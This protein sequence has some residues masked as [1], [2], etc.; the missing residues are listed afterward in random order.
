MSLSRIFTQSSK[1]RNLSTPAMDETPSTHSP[2]EPAE[3]LPRHALFF[4]VSVSLGLLVGSILI[5][6]ALATGRSQPPTDATRALARVPVMHAVQAVVARQWVGF[7]ISTAERAS[8]VPARVTATVAAIPE[9]TKEGLT[10][11]V[12]QVL[13]ELDAD[14]F[15]QQRKIADEAIRSLDAQITALSIQTESLVEQVS[16]ASQELELA[17]ADLGRIQSAFED[18]AARQREVDNA[19]QRR[20]QFARQVVLLTE[21]SSEMGPRRSQLDS[22]MSSQQSSRE[23]A[24]RNE[25]R[26]FVR[27]PIDG[28]L[29]SVS[30]KLGEIVTAGMVVARVVDPSAVEIELKLP[31]Q[32][33]ASIALG[34]DAIVMDG[35]LS[36]EGTLVGKVLRIAP[37]DDSVTRTM[38][39]FIEFSGEAA[40]LVPPGSLVE[41]SVQSAPDGARTVVPRR[42][43][44]S[45]RVHR[46]VNGVVDAIPIRRAYPHDGLILESGLLDTAWVV[47]E[48]PL[49]PEMVIVIDASSRVAEPGSRVDPIMLS[50]NGST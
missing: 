18:G 28:V 35:G 27:A 36:H 4:R 15:R 3:T 49:P 26:C 7:G 30:L 9:T 1:V 25:E 47:L 6:I 33:R 24:L 10:V 29:Q 21:Q 16:L 17:E 12:G 42:A 20:I 5:F 48:E 11:A 40:R 31:A 50:G 2:G 23:L 39:A 34:D 8:V 37:E 14:D 43:I 19:K 44:R 45:D 46:V 32:A 13:V 38:S 22:Q 41:M